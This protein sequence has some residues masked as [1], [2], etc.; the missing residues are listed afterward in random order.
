LKLGLGLAGVLAA[1]GW[2]GVAPALRDASATRDKIAAARGALDRSHTKARDIRALADT[3]DEARAFADANAKPL[4]DLD[5]SAV[6][7]DI[8]RFLTALRVTTHQMTQ[9]RAVER[10]GVLVTPI[11]LVMQ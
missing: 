10:S 7:H 1:A 6:M 8:G 3:L 4:V 2:L 9:D 11:T 5:I